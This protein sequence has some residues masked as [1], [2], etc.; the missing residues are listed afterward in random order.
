MT[1]SETIKV[2]QGS[3]LNWIVRASGFQTQSGTI[4]SV[5]EHTSFPVYLIGESSTTAKLKINPTPSNATII[6][7]E[8]EG[9]EKDIVKGTMATYTVSADIYFPITETTDRM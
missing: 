6:I 7:N 8:V 5:M 9:G 2:K 1:K 4:D 3:K